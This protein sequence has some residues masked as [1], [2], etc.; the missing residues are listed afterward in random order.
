LIAAIFEAC[1]CL[2]FQG[3]SAQ[4][5]VKQMVK[6]YRPSVVY[7]KVDKTAGDS[8]AVTTE[9]GTGFVVSKFGH[10]LT[11][12]HVIDKRLRD[13]DGK[14]L[15]TPVEKVT[16]Q[17]AM[18]SNAGQLEP[19]TALQCAQDPVDL[20]LLRFNNSA[21]A[22]PPVPV[23]PEQPDIGDDLASMGFALNT[24]FF[25]RPGTLSSLTADD[26]LLVSMVLNPGDS[27]APVFDKSLRVIGV[28]EA[29]YGF[30]TGIGVVRPIRHGAL[31]LAIAGVNLYA[32]NAKIVSTPLPNQASNPNIYTANFADAIKKFG[33]AGNSVPKN[34]K[35]ITV[36][37]PFL[38]AKASPKTGPTSNAP[39]V[40]D[41]RTIPAAPGY[42][43][44][45]AK[46]I[47]TEGSP[48]SILHVGASPSGNVVR[49]ALE[50][51]PA[52]SASQSTP[53]KGFIETTQVKLAH[54]PQ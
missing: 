29:G 21:I 33:A 24:D 46:F 34:S 35:E 30:G 37:Y 20:A 1:G 8:G 13:A 7:L 26:T 36:T 14:V 12:C 27:G 23:F 43:I 18:A 39:P 47:V 42:K 45:G 6:G 41:V 31:L 19:M 49:A 4:E 25:A 28:A 16:V 3:A 10:V 53:L 15:A 44:V 2:I 38:Q 54:S 5:F 9:I 40:V 11:S 32:V 51:A 22:R 48:A 17:G 52:I 50:G